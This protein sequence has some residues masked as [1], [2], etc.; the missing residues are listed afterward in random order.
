MKMRSI[1]RTCSGI[2]L[3]AFLFFSCEKN[4]PSGP[5]PAGL[6]VS[7]EGIEFAA[8]T[9]MTPVAE[10]VWDIYG[11]FVAGQVVHVTETGG[12]EDFV[13]FKV[14][15]LKDGVCRLRVKA[16]KSWSLVRIEKVS[17]VVTEG[18]AGDSDKG[19]KPPIE[20]TYKGGG[21]WTVDK[22][23]VATDHI[24]YRYELETDTPS[25]LKYWCAT[26]DNAGTAP[27]ALSP[28]Y[29]K[30]RSLGQEEYDN[31]KLKDN[32]AC[33]MFPAEPVGKLAG[34]TILMQAEVPS[35]EIVFSTAHSGPKAGF[36]GDSI[37]WLW[38]L[39]YYNK[40]TP[41]DMVYPI[42]P[43]PSWARIV[44]SNI[45]LYFHKSFFDSNNYINKGVSGNNTTQMVARFK[46][47]ILDQDPQC[48]V[49]MGG[50]NDL[51]QG[52]T[53]MTIL[54]NI[55]KMAEDADALD[56]RVILCSVTPCNDEYS[57]LNP[58]NKGVHIV[59]LNQMIKDYAESKGFTWCDY[60]PYLV[61]ED[62]YTLKEEYWMYDHLHPNPDAYTVMEG[63]IKPI[64]EEVIK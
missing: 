12:E 59:E 2:F 19:N 63:I 48:V 55:K 16:D 39:D 23:Y 17:L 31:L 27:A 29:L 41:S 1:F 40:K 45:W 37:T 34:F 61:A 26:W 4:G 25:E 50:T 42:D 28:E 35:Q 18:G 62:G 33:W 49:I 53:K 8:G 5:L 6:E 22:L 46:K 15:P 21:V 44:G 30:V 10:G 52:E 51:A 57:R 54:S 58:K 13:A 36:I 60:Y 43:L 14:T 7:G 24:R 38:G 11:D 9:P 64:I 47:E 20:A 56:I 3:A 32:R